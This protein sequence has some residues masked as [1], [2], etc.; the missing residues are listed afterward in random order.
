MKM[1]SHL[2]NLSL[3]DAPDSSVE[4]QMLFS[5]QQVVQSVHLRAV[6]D[7][8]PLRPAVHDVHHPPETQHA[9]QEQKTRHKY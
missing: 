6:A 3:A 4:V 7:I 2:I 1:P 5:R 8:Y 9:H